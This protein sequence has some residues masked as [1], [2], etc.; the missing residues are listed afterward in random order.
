MFF[1]GSVRTE[2]NSQKS[3]WWPRIAWCICGALHPHFPGGS[4]VKA[5]ACNAGG[6]GSIPG[7]GRSPG[8][9]NGNP[10]Q[11]SCPENPMDGGAWW[12]TLVLGVA[13]SRTRLSDFTFTFHPHYTQ[14]HTLKLHLRML[15]T[16]WSLPLLFVSSNP[17][18]VHLNVEAKMQSIVWNLLQGHSL[19]E[20]SA[21]LFK[22]V[23]LLF[24]LSP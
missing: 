2:L 12:A 8:E 9:G 15:K 6:L 10:L 20:G 17:T 18:L 19:R 11:Y 16:L 24:L 14:T 4:E 23:S 5:S 22:W 13:K 21:G 7:S 1:L 3:C